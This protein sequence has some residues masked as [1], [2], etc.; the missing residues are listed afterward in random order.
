MASHASAIKRAKQNEKRRLRNLNIKTLVKSS[1]KKVRTAIEK[2]DVEEGGIS[3]PGPHGTK[4]E[5]IDSYSPDC[6]TSVVYFYL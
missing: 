2:K 1:I 5:L 3:P 4:C 6:A